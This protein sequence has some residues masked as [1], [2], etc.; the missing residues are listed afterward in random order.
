[1]KHLLKYNFDVEVSLHPV[2]DIYPVEIALLIEPMVR[3]AAL[4]YHWDGEFPYLFMICYKV[5]HRAEVFLSPERSQL[6]P[7]KATI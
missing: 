1:M 2:N 7:H 4:K 5:Q 6:L 3:C